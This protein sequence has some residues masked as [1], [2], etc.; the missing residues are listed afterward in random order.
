MTEC[1]D[2]GADVIH[3][4]RHRAFETEARREVRWVCANCHPELPDTLGE[5]ATETAETA[6][7]VDGAETATTTDDGETVVMTD[8]GSSACPDCGAATVNGQGLFSCLDCTWT[9]P[10]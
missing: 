2:C 1:N 8:G 6:E 4:W 7:A 5:P 10:C 3:V 9:G